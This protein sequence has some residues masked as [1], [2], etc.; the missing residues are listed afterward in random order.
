MNIAVAEFAPHSSA[1]HP[2]EPISRA[3]ALRA[4]LAWSEMVIE[5]GE[6][7]RAGGDYRSHARALLRE[8]YDFDRGPVLLK[9]A[10][11]SGHPIRTEFEDIASYYVG[12]G[13]W[14]DEGFALKP[15]RKIRFGRQYASFGQGSA[16]LMGSC[17]LTPAR[18]AVETQ[19]D[20]TMG[21]RRDPQGVA[22]MTLH[23]SSAPFRPIRGADLAA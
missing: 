5:I 21:F 16:T 7:V 22:R 15:W 13:V 1:A 20:F 3:D 10:F 12:G 18:S 23:H 14:E 6:V 2:N 4:Q 11:A 8:V 17:F 19:L 9:P